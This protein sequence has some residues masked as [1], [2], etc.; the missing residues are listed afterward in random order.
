MDPYLMAEIWIAAAVVFGGAA[1][2]YIA[3]DR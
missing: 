3:W 2:G 1:L